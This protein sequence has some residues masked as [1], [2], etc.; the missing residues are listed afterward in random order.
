MKIAISSEGDNLDSNVDAKFGR[1]NYFLIVNVENGKIKDIKVIENSAK[2]QMGGAGITAGEII[3]K[4]KVDAVISA[5]V[6]PRAFSVFTQFG[7]KV[8]RGEGKIKQV[9]RDLIDEKLE[10]IN[11][12]TGPQ[13]IGPK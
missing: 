1:C 8:F 4:E 3:A 13:N 10:E 7:I 6:G 5:N 9:V 12:A 2:E 11:D